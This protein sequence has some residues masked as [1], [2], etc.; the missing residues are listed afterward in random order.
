MSTP[1]PHRIESPDNRVFK[2][3]AKTLDVRG[4]RKL[5]RALVSGPKTVA[6]VLRDSSGLVEAWISAPSHPAP[7]NLPP[8][9]KWYELAPPLFGKLDAAG[10]GAPML[11]V[12]VPD[13]PTWNPDAIVRGCTLLVPF[14][15]PENVGTVIRSAV[16]FGVEH[17]VLLDES[18]HP[19][20][21]KA[22]RASG[23]AVFA[24]KLFDGPPLRAV[25][26]GV[27]VVALSA[28]G[29][30]IADFA[31]PDRFVLLPGVEGPGLPERFHS[32]ALAIPMTGKVESL[33][34]AAATSIAL[35]LWSQSRKGT[36]G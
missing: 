32:Q 36:R 11:L 31:F 30:S 27:P 1:S 35:Y 6:D 26:D 25:P 16:A 28:G 12:K 22:V 3:L 29:R 10:T 2:Q 15:D 24:A 21:P 7:S 19:F 18:A 34:A 33:N 17:V 14:Q 20:H 4:I 23:G 9:A 5:E 8:H 13:I